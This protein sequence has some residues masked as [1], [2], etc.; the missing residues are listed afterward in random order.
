[1]RDSRLLVLAAWM[2]A[3]FALDGEGR[4]D[5]RAQTID[6]A[7]QRNG[8]HSCPVG[9]FVTGV[10]LERNQLLCS[11]GFGGYQN[12]DEVVDHDTQMTG[13]HPDGDA[14]MHGCPAGMVVTG[15]YGGELLNCAPLSRS[16]S[17]FVDKKTQIMG[18]HACPEGTVMA[19]L[20]ASRNW[21]L[22]GTF[23]EFLSG[24]EMHRNDML[25]CPP[26][27]FITG[28]HIGTNKLLC[29]EEFGGWDT[30]SVHPAEGG[31][32]RCPAGMAATG[33]HNGRRLVACAP[34]ARR[35]D[36]WE[37]S[38]MQRANMSACPLGSVALGFDP[39][40]GDPSVGGTIASGFAYCGRVLSGP[41]K[42]AQR[43]PR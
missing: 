38:T 21:L 30:E 37:L 6:H 27:M 17:L 2:G 3:W 40:M 9:T 15:V 11:S 10:H 26:G 18:M 42:P 8:M 19:G 5:L 20:H 29:T 24:E 4:G 23:Q 12:A 32:A 13:W 28:V 1:M 7:T 33:L 16:P 35:V 39:W 36:G 43:F 22:C 41:R 34:I 31:P 25:S 14:T